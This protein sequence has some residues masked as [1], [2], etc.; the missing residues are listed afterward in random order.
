MWGMKKQFFALIVVVAVL[1][2]AMVVW[3]LPL[4]RRVTKRRLA[5]GRPRPAGTSPARPAP[6]PTPPPPQAPAGAR[7]P[8]A[9]L[10]E[11]HNPPDDP[12]EASDPVSDA[13][14]AAPRAADAAAAAPPEPPADAPDTPGGPADAPDAPGGPTGGSAAAGAALGAQPPGA[15]G[16]ADAERM[17]AVREAMAHSWGGYV[18][19]AWGHDELKPV[20]RSYED[21]QCSTVHGPCPSHSLGLTILDCMD[22][23]WVMG[24]KEQWAQALGFVQSELSFRR[25]M[26]VSVFETTIR[27]LGGLLGAYDLSGERVLLDK[28]QELGDR[29]IRAFD[30][31]VFPRVRRPRG[32]PSV[33]LQPPRCRATVS[34]ALATETADW[35]PV[36]AVAATLET[37]L[38]FT[39]LY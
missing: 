17:A 34:P 28:A 31:G 10:A 5:G 6:V 13:A 23:L 7:K 3:N 30:N 33:P 12:A 15:F 26:K 20:S 2:W 14:D 32:R 8:P 1:L 35:P 11:D 29:L 24:L 25:G 36:H 22:T 4:T 37:V 18:K 19:Y 9:G 27:M 39:G 16:N 38:S 21:W